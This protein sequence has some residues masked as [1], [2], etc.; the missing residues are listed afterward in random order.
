MGLLVVLIREG[1]EHLHGLGVS[2]VVLIIFLPIFFQPTSTQPL[3]LYRPLLHRCGDSWREVQHIFGDHPFLPILPRPEVLLQTLLI[4][5]LNSL[6]LLVHLLKLPLHI[7]QLQLYLLKRH[8]TWYLN[9]RMQILS[10]LQSMSSPLFMFYFKRRRY[11]RDG[12][13]FFWI[14][15]LLKLLADL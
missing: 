13:R 3:L 12:C 7:L 11:V 4:R 6:T 2:I 15:V 8:L 10:Q 5:L 14:Y 9:L 1:V